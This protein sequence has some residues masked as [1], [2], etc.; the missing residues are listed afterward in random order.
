MTIAASVLA[1]S[2][3]HGGADDPLLLNSQLGST[4]KGNKS[5]AMGRRPAAA[6][7][8]TGSALAIGAMLV[9][10]ALAVR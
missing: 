3:G 7:I 9:G 1:T 4:S 2:N 8:L 10:R 6:L 5:G